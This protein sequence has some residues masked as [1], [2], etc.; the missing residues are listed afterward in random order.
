MRV[1][2]SIHGGPVGLTILFLKLEAALKTIRTVRLSDQRCDM[3]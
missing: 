2:G 3:G 1:I